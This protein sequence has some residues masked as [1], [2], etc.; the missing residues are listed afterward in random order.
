MGLK[1]QIRVQE[2]IKNEKKKTK[3]NE[4]AERTGVSLGYYERKTFAPNQ[5]PILS[6]ENRVICFQVRVISHGDVFILFEVFS[7]TLR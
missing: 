1:R 2:V 7:W 4:K 5:A 6:F 3:K